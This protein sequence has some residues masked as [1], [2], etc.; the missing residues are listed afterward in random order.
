M[1]TVRW[2]AYAFLVA[3][4]VAAVAAA[5]AVMAVLAVDRAPQVAPPLES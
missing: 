5:V 3:L 4:D 2:R 1:K